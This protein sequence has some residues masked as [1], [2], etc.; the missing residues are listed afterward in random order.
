MAIKQT[1]FKIWEGASPYNSAPISSIITGTDGSSNNPKTGPMIQLWIIPKEINPKDAVK[2]GED[3]CV[4]GDCPLRPTTTK[5]NNFKP[6]YVGRRAW[7]AP[8][9]VWQYN[10]GRKVEL[11]KSWCAMKLSNLPIRIGAY[12]DGAMMPQEIIQK[13]VHIAD[14]HTCYTHMWKQK[15]AQWIK[16]YSMASVSSVGDAKIAWKKSWRTFRISNQNDCTDNEI[17]CPHI[18]HNVQ[19]IKCNLCN[20]KVNK[21]DKRKSI[22][23]IEH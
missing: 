18:T 2:T 12:G 4:C 15:W 19:C 20:G 10:I 22:V 23:I 5:T 17:M 8:R 9:S 13:L 3:E 6:C 14:G 1:S 11:E 7:Q 16:K 21:N